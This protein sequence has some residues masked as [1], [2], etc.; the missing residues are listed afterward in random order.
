MTDAS[1]RLLSVAVE[2]AR[3]AGEVAL[4]YYRGGCDVTLKPDATPVTR[5]DLE[6]EEV[7]RKIIGRAFPDHG[8]LGDEFGK[9]G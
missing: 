4:K 2:A 3:A 6:A 8:F 7:I 5:A 1:D 9:E